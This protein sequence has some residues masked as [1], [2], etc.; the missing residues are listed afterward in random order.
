MRVLALRMKASDT[1]TSMTY[2]TLPT[3]AAFDAVCPA[4]FKVTLND[5]DARL[6]HGAGLFELTTDGEWSPDTLWEVIGALEA[7]YAM[8]SDEH[9]DLAS[10][11]LSC[12]GF[13]WV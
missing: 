5:R 3:R 9:G 6:V 12:L 7:C 11:L 13:E 8:G 4:L 1:M 2:G 10:T